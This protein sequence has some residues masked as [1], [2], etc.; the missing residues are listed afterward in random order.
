MQLH[1]QRVVDEKSELDEKLAKLKV[2]IAS[3]RY[4]A[5]PGV[6]QSLLMNQAYYMNSYSSILGS[7]IYLFS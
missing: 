2:F 6:E 1:E 3:E 7:R 5:L 4:Q